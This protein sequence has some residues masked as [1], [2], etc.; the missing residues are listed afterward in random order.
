M[1]S[2]QNVGDRSFSIEFYVVCLSFI[3]LLLRLL[4][5]RFRMAFYFVTTGGMLEFG[6]Y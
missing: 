4:S 2:I 5:P 3:G 6:V 1:L